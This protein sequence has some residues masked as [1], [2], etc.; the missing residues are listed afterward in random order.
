MAKTGLIQVMRGI[1]DNL[2]GMLDRSKAVQGYLNR[3]VYRQ[4][5]NAQRARWMSENDSEGAKWKALDPK[6]AARKKIK[7]ASYPGAG[8]KMLIATSRLF[9]A[10]VGEGSNSEG[11][12]EHRKTATSK[13]LEIK[14]ST[15][16]AVY[17]DDARPFSEFGDKTMQEIYDGLAK[18]LIE[19][20][21]RS[22]GRGW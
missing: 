2:Q 1:E 19:N 7:F 21:L 14:W 3:N 22:L 20:E 18:F 11:K 5:Q 10:V 8:S 4:Y 6:Y 16:Y 12:S 15:P 13:S 17:V 9:S